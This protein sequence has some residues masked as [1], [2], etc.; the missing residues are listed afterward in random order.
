[1]GKKNKFKNIIVGCFSVL[2]G[3]FAMTWVSLA[4]TES[5][6]ACI[7][8]PPQALAYGDHTTGC[9]ISPIGDT[10]QFTFT[11]TIDDRVRFNVMSTSSNM[12][13]LLEVR[14]PGGNLIDSRSCSQFGC[15]FSLD[16]I[17]PAS[18]T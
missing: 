3:S 5:P 11:G 7:E 12:D 8:G 18:G 13:P 6:I 4:E 16:M 14:D 15:T 10:D 2:L 9:V 1:M 17:L